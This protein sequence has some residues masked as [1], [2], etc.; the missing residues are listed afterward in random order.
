MSYMQ[1]YHIRRFSQQNKIQNYAFVKKWVDKR[2]DICAHLE[3][4]Q[5]RDINSCLFVGNSYLLCYIYTHWVVFPLF[6][7]QTVCDL[8]LYRNW[9]DSNLYDPVTCITSLTIDRNLQLFSYSW[10]Y[11]IVYLIH[12]AFEYKFWQLTTV[13]PCT[14]TNN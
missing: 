11:F 8:K 2:C 10:T 13:H 14:C 5:V 9:Q 12:R 7:K 4:S 3:S 6:I 1:N